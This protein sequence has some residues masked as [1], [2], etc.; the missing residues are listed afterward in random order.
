VAQSAPVVD[1]ARLARTGL[2]VLTFINLFNYIDRYVVAALGESLRHSPLHVSDTQ[3]GLLTSGFIVV[4]M[5]AAP[6]FGTLGD[7]GSRRR[8]IAAGVFIW[9]V[10]TAVGGL[11]WSFVSLLGARALVGVG[12]AAYGTIAPSLLADYFPR[13]YRGR[14]FSIFFAAIPVGTA[15][16]YVIGGALDVQFG[17]RSAFFFV[18]A[19]G[20]ALAALSLRLYDPP[21]GIQDPT[22]ALRASHRLRGAARAAYATLARSRL[23]VLTVLGYAAYT[24]ALGGMAVFLPKFLMRVRGLTE[25]MTTIGSGLVLVATGLLGTTVGG[26]AADRLLVRTR[27][28]DLWV[29]GVATLLAAPVAL[30]ALVAPSPPVYWTTLVLAELLLFS[31][32]GPIN[33]AIVN[34]VAPEMRATAV[35]VSILAIHVLGDVPSPTILGAISDAS[36]LARAVLIIPAA[37][38]LGG[39]IWTYGAWRGERMAG[40][41]PSP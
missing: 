27:Q 39:V 29:S 33:S 28:A 7:T 26:W 36:T 16:G 25:G 24:F 34:L 38:L 22:D 9:S 40:V 5:L 15:L 37:I 30:V 31:S 18:G 17:W 1:S 32:T 2:V 23:Y 41:E 14:V 10:A 4:Y 3:F 35:A 13:Q 20:L 21:R 19:P 12:E 11:A 6:V 8:L